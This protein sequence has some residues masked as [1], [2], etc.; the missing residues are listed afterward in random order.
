MVYRFLADLVVVVH[1]AFVLFVV[2]GGLLVLRRPR[3]SW[4]HL[5]AAA[6]GALIEFA[7]WIC[8]LTPLENHLRR[9]GG[10]AGYA[11]GFVEEYLLALLY[12]SGLTRIH[13]LALGALVLTLNLAMYGWLWWR[14]RER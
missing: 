3:L 2:A 5:P 6:W 9:L 7:G 4:L 13:Q 11:G 12:P 1:L 14:R 8:P 10:E